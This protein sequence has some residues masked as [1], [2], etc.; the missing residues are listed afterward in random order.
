MILNFENA[1]LYR[2]I[3]PLYESGTETGKWKVQSRSPL[4]HYRLLASRHPFD[5]SSP[6]A[7]KTRSMG[8]MKKCHD[9]NK[10]SSA[11]C[12]L[13]IEKDGVLSRFVTDPEFLERV[14]TAT[15]Y[16]HNSFRP[17]HFDT[18]AARANYGASDA[19]SPGS[20]AG[21]TAS[22]SF[23]SGPSSEGNSPSLVL[24]PRPSLVAVG[25][26]VRKRVKGAVPHTPRPRKP[27]TRSQGACF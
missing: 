8:L 21:S 24:S 25:A 22:A 20:S 26:G 4:A 18:V 5:M 23:T 12:A 11:R 19:S 9:L 13:F 16:A 3:G 15:V 6:R 7:V 1:K 10:L 14:Q 27:V 2:R 17:D